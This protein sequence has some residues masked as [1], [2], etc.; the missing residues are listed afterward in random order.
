[1]VIALASPVKLYAIYLPMAGKHTLDLRNTQGTF[2]ISWYDP[3]AGGELQ[4]GSVETAIGGEIVTLG[5]PPVLTTKSR[6]QD[7]IVLV[8]KTE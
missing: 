3:L 7:W 2:N 6:G 1:M 4:T 5:N 8:K